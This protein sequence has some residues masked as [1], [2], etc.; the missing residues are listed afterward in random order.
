MNIKLVME[1]LIEK[2]NSSDIGK[3]GII[4]FL[5]PYSYLYY[6]SHKDV[7]KSFDKIYIDGIFLVHM[8]KICGVRTERVSFDMTSLAPSFFGS[9]IENNESVYFIGSTEDNL[10]H[11]VEVIRA[12]FP[13]LEISGYRNGYFKSDRER[14]GALNTISELG[15]N[16]VVVGMGSPY[17]EIF[18]KDLKKTGWKGVGYTCGGFIHQTAKGINYYPK[19]F[20]QYNLR[21]LYRIIDEPKLLKRYLFH[22]PLS[23]CLFTF[24]AIQYKLRH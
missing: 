10:S 3:N 22:Y 21:W 17:Q 16:N 4:T 11:F 7:F 20:N 2:L 1:L 9:C 12:N 6:R 5:N 18:L 14:E 8:M 23:I 24:D 13:D 15:P 19:F